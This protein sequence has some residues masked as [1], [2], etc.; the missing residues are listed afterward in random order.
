[1]HKFV[2]ALRASRLENCFNPYADC[3]RVHDLAEAPRIRAAMLSDLVEQAESRDVD[4]IWIG[5]DLGYR[6][7]RRTGLALTDDFHFSR[8]LE[9][10]GIESSRPTAG[11]LLAERTASIV[12]ELLNQIPEDIFLWNVFP[13]HPHDAGQPF[14][15][16]QHSRSERRI[17]EDILAHLIEVLRPSRIIAIGNDA[18]EVAARHSKRLPMTGVRHP[19]YGGQTVFRRQVQDLYALRQPTLF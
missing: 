11:P 6:G 5:R 19:S 4:A 15:N 3:C 10:W 1:M 12:W 8:H 17:G 18:A 7:G 2:A 13:F 9:R 16:R 14:S